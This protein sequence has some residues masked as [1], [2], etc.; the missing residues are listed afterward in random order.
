MLM[1]SLYFCLVHLWSFLSA[2]S[3]EISREGMVGYICD[4]LLKQEDC[5]F[6][7]NLG[8]TMRRYIKKREK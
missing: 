5:E 4:V 6:E 8:Y 3:Q 1:F 2:E 7:A